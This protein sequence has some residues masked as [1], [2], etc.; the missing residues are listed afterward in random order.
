MIAFR[1]RVGIV[2]SGYY[3][4]P[5]KR[6]ARIEGEPHPAENSYR[7]SGT[8]ME[9]QINTSPSATLTGR[10]RCRTSRSPS[11]KA[12]SDCS[13]PTARASPRSCVRWPRCRKPT[14]APRAWT[15]SMCCVTKTGAQG[16]RLP[17]AGVRPLS[18]SSGRNSALAFCSAEG[19]RER[20]RTSRSRTRASAPD[21]PVGPP[22][23]AAGQ[24]FRRHEAAL[25]HCAGAVWAI[26]G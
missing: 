4:S 17:A 18:E 15:E 19:H 24:F 1:I 21:Q 11:H 6:I 22:Q 7:V 9:L 13:A 16:A 8:S 20:R 5:I 23:Q 12:C 3:G 2:P 25:R 10:R 14:V 26:R